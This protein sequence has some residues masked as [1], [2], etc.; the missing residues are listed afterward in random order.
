[1]SEIEAQKL[2]DF[3]QVLNLIYKVKYVYH[4]DSIEKEADKALLMCAE[5]HDKYGGD[6][7]VSLDTVKELAWR[8]ISYVV[9]HRAGKQ[10][11]AKKSIIS[12]MLEK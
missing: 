5:L 12:K 1:M 10:Y 9:S 8:N 3:M 4:N 7:Q 2:K 11:T 6:A